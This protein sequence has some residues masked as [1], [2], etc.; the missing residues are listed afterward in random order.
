MKT[1]MTL[2][3]LQDKHFT[4]VEEFFHS[5]ALQEESQIFISKLSKTKDRIALVVLKCFES[6]KNP[7]IADGGMIIELNYKWSLADILIKSW[8]HEYQFDVVQFILNYEQSLKKKGFYQINDPIVTLDA[9]ASIMTTYIAE[10]YLN[11]PVI[12][13]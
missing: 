7:F 9:Y 13:I 11:E 8:K 5:W 1:K 10:D 6:G 12:P 3:E 2:K 4:I